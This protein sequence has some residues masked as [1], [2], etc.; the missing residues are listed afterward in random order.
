M[1]VHVFGYACDVDK[2]QKIADK[3]NLKIIYDAAHAFGAVYKGKSLCSY[4]DISML[5][6]H[7][8]KLFHTIEGGGV[9]VKDDAVDQKFDLSKRFGH[10]E[11]DDHRQL[12]INAKANEFQAAM[13]LC[14]LKYVDDLIKKRKQVSEWYDKYLN[15]EVGRPAKQKDLQYNYAY[16]SI[17]LKNENQ[18]FKVV[19]ALKDVGVSVRRYFWPSL[20]NLPY[21][22]EKQSCPVSENISSRVLSIPL[23][24]DLPEEDIRLISETIR[25]VVNA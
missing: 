7:A 10:F 12:G 25:K 1:P 3:H 20:N 8:T 9:V 19:A 13:G 21:L 18:L 5:S 22:K 16:Y 2:I 23:Y 15:G 24:S 14:N 4:G 11:G 17:L 6:F